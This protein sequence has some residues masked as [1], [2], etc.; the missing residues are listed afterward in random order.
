MV[1]ENLSNNRKAYMNIKFEIMTVS[2][3]VDF[4]SI[5]GK[6]KK[7]HLSYFWE[8]IFFKKHHRYPSPFYSE[9]TFKIFKTVF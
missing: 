8:T 7:R 3:R 5:E 1:I 9:H 2:I 6:K 4:P